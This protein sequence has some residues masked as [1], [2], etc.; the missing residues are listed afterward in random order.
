MFLR[1]A[2]EQCG[3]ILLRARSKGAI[4]SVIATR[5]SLVANTRTDETREAPREDT[6]ST[7]HDL[8]KEP[9]RIA[10]SALS[11]FSNRQSSFNPPGLGASVGRRVVFSSACSPAVSS[12]AASSLSE[13]KEEQEDPRTRTQSS[14][15]AESNATGCTPRPFARPPITDATR[16][17]IHLN[18]SEMCQLLYNSGG[19][20]TTNWLL[21]GAVSL[22]DLASVL[23]AYLPP[24][25]S[26]TRSRITSVTPPKKNNQNEQVIRSSSSH[27][28]AGDELQFS[29]EIIDLF[30][31]HTH[32]SSF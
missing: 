8:Q 20:T 28:S 16:S 11:S 24:P 3:L 26:R 5:K 17:D 19:S 7:N 15:P 2:P 18:P 27:P 10:S 30:G 21:S 14:A 9:R 25:S 32:S 22:S 12:G 29:D 13:R 6:H 23:N 31:W 1:D 4:N